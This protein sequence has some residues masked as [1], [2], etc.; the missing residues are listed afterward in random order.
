M[1]METFNAVSS[2]H[3]WNL[4]SAIIGGILGALAGGVPAFTIAKRQSEE[5]IKR[6]REQRQE[7]EKA[8]A[9][10]ALVTLITITN[11]TVSLYRHVLGHL[12]LLNEPRYKLSQPWQVLRPMVGFSDEG[13]QRLSAEQLAVFVAAGRHD[14]AMDAMLL[15]QRHAATLSSFQEYCELRERLTPQL[16]APESYAGDVGASYLTPDQV[17]QLMPIIIP[18]NNLAAQLGAHLEADLTLGRKVSEGFGPITRAYFKDDKFPML[19]FPTDEEVQAG[20]AEAASD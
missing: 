19:G 7:R 5:S 14:Y 6:E 20:F 17:M 18:L 4:M 1:T 2:E 15:A 12:R 9:F 16:P 13:E 3:W 8:L 10:A 11:S